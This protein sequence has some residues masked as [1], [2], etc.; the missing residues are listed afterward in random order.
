MPEGV[1]EE[2]IYNVD[3]DIEK[4]VS[5]L[6]EM[7]PLYIKENTKKI[8]G[9]W[10][11]SYTFS[12]HLAEKYLY[13]H[14]GNINILIARP[15]VVIAAIDDPFKGW[16]DTASAGGNIIM[17]AGLGINPFMPLAKGK[18]VDIIP[19][20]IVAK[21]MLVGASFVGQQNGILEVLNIGSTAN[22]NN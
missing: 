14:R 17:T 15:A 22:P 7:D 5:S 8:I 2:K 10:P 1:I 20:D 16:T 12:K 9:D 11:N 3:Q 18:L 21:T 4:L 13:K 19:V 6:M